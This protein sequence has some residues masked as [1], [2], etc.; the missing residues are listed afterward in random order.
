MLTLLLLI[1]AQ[2]PAP[3]KSVDWVEV[4]QRFHGDAA[5][6][7]KAGAPLDLA[8]LKLEKLASDELVRELAARETSFFG[9]S[10]YAELWALARGFGLQVDPTPDAF[11]V[12]FLR[13]TGVARPAWYLPARKAVLIDEDEYSDDARFDRPLLQALALASF[14]Q[15]PGGL[16]APAN[17]SSTESLLCARAWIEGRARRV[18]QIARGEIGRAQLTP[19]ELRQGGFALLESVGLAAAWRGSTRPASGWEFLH[20]GNAPARE[21]LSLGALAPEGAKLVREDTLGEFGLRYLLSF[22]GAHPVR[23][24]EAGIG[25]RADRLRLWSY[26]ERDWEFAWRLSFEREADAAQLEELLGKLARGT[27][28]RHG[29]VYDWCW[30]TRPEREA[31]LARALAALPLPPASDEKRARA[32]EALERSA[33]AVQPHAEGERWLLPEMDLAW[34][35]PA[36][37]EPSFYMGE[38]IVYLAAPE[39]GF[40]DNLTFREFP[41]P[42]DATPEK[43]LAGAKQLFAGHAGVTL[44]RAELAH[45]PVGTAVL[46]EYTQRAG[47]SELHQLELQLVLPGRKRALTATLLAKHW[48]KNGATVEALLLASEHA[49]PAK[50]PEPRK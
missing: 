2:D 38:P 35:F 12:T 41:L 40:R 3:F 43:V 17:G 20:E 1:A 31:D 9:V 22:A 4:L 48:E 29:Y 39:D 13:M 30:A 33:L 15:Q 18:A 16:E 42:D 24:I 6:V 21:E 46:L 5:L 47:K 34:K 28:V 27:R 14:D 10:W 8:A 36:G 7:Q 50:A 23:A 32:A 37:C 45:P 49:A 25:L 44:V 26:G 19:L 11:R